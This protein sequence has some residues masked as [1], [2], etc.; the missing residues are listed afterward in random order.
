MERTM[1][2][3]RRYPGMVAAGQ[4]T[5]GVVGRWPLPTRM[6]RVVTRPRTAGLLVT[7]VILILAWQLNPNGPFQSDGDATI[8]PMGLTKKA[9]EAATADPAT[10]WL[11]LSWLVVDAVIFLLLAPRWREVRLGLARNPALPILLLLAWASILWSISPEDTLRRAAAVTATTLFG[12]YLGSRFH[13]L[14]LAELAGRAIWLTILASLLFIALQPQRGMN[15]ELYPGAWRGVFTNKN[16]F[17][18]VM[19]TGCLCYYAGWLATSRR[20]YLA[21]FA[22]AAALLLLSQAKTPLFIAMAIAPTF[23]LIRRYSAASRK[24][25]WVLGSTM[26]L[27]LVLSLYIVPNFDSILA[28]FGK[29]SSL[30][31]RTNVWAS[32][33]EAIQ[34]RFW[35][36]YGYGAFWV[37]DGPASQIWESLVWRTPNAHNGILELWLNLGLFGVVAFVILCIAILLRIFRTASTSPRPWI[38]WTMGFAMMFIGYCI[39]ESNSMEQND[40]SWV[41]FCALAVDGAKPSGSPGG[42]RAPAQEPAR[43]Y[44]RWNASRATRS[45][46]S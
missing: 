14:E 18:H 40:L 29:D 36:G 26:C 21:K 8:D 33:W 32:C 13:Q 7:T 34:E 16:P 20:Q 43:Q 28:F 11:R 10:M 38:T 27:L 15:S 39:N 44:L 23:V 5:A 19:L 46:L 17:G 31:G 30:S 2:M 35:L 42:R 37:D 3:S 4:P 41:M 22:V 24:F 6:G 45:R 25:A 1:A 9:L 12:V